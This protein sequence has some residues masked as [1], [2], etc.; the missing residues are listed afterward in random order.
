MKIVFGLIIAKTFAKQFF[1]QILN[2]IAHA[3]DLV[4][5][6]GYNLV[7]SSTEKKELH[8]KFYRFAVQR[9]VL[10]YIGFSILMRTGLH[11]WISIRIE[12]TSNKGKSCQL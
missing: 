9:K 7:Q 1:F 5:I 2:K 10:P 12:H 4:S 11:L 6:Q 8:M 3:L